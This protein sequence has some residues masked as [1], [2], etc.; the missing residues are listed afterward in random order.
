MVAP[1]SRGLRG[2]LDSAEY[3]RFVQQARETARFR[4]G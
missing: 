2:Y 4:L 1:L 3:G